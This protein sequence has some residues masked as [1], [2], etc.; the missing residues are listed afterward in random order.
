MY[1]VCLM[2]PKLFSSEYEEA[3]VSSDGKHEKFAVGAHV[4]VNTQ[5]VVISRCCFTE[6][7]YEMY[8]ILLCTCRAIVLLIKPFVLPRSRCRCRRG[9]LKLPNVFNMTQKFFFEDSV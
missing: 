1:S 8:Q 4:L 7:G 2:V 3:G 9:L 6:D 5:N